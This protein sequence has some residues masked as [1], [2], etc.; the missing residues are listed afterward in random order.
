MANDPRDMTIPDDL[1]GGGFPLPFTGS[2]PKMTSVR[3]VTI[4]LPSLP[5]APARDN[6]TINVVATEEN[7]DLSIDVSYSGAEPATMEEYLAIISLVKTL[8]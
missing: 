1:V 8:L 2:P 5:D 4:P 7:G 3:T 6:P